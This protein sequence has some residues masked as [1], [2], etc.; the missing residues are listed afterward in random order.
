MASSMSVS[1][2]GIWPSLN[3]AR[4]LRAAQPAASRARVPAHHQAET[5]PES[6][7]SRLELLTLLEPRVIHTLHGG[8]HVLIAC[9]QTR[10]PCE[11]MQIHGAQ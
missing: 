8:E 11:P 2:R 9:D 7:A 4:A 6:G 3:M 1:A 5:Q 10:G